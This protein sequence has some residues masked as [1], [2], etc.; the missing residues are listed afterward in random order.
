MFQASLDIFAES[1]QIASN[2]VFIVISGVLGILGALAEFTILGAFVHFKVLWAIEKV[3]ILGALL[4]KEYL[5]AIL[6][7]NPLSL[8]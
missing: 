1:Y 7:S 4:K 3:E 8:V 6:D 5:W 2:I